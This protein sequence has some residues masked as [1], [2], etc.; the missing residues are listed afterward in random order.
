MKIYIVFNGRED[1][2]R[3]TM[4][5]FDDVFDDGKPIPMVF[6]H[7]A[8]AISGLEAMKAY[9]Y[10]NP[11]SG[12]LVRPFQDAYIEEIEALE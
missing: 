9:A 5:S 4:A 11:L 3:D 12:R 1:F 7:K 8:A 6:T 2:G 10:A